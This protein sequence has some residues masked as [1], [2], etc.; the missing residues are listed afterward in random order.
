MS[1]KTAVRAAVIAMVAALAAFVVAALAGGAVS[2]KV[3]PG[4]GD[5][6]LLTRWG[7][8]IS[9]VALELTS[10]LTVGALMMAAFLLPAGKEGLGP[11][12]RRYVR[13][14]SW[15]AACWAVAAAATMVFTVS[16]ILAEP[17]GT[18]L[19]GNELSSYVGQLPEGTALM[20]VVLMSVVVALLARTTVS[21]GG[22]VGLLVLAF[23]ALLPEPVTTGHSAASPNHSVAI[24]SMALHI[25]G[26]V[27]WVGGLALLAWFAMTGGEAAL[28][29]PAERFS[30]AALVCYV[31]VGASGFANVV[32]R[33]ADPEQLFTSDYGRLVLVK[34]AAFAFLGWLGWTHRT[35]TLPAVAVRKPR[36][37]IRL[38]AVEVAIMAGTVGVAVALSRTPPPAESTTEDP[39]KSLL[40]YSM[41]PPLTTGR[42]F[43]LWRFDLYFAVLVAVLGGLYVAG[44]LRLRRRGDRWPVGRT[45]A[46]MIGL[47]TIVVVTMSG[48]ATY[49][50]ILF[51]VHMAQHMVLSML[52]PIF[53]VLGAPITLALRALKPA[54]VRG[55]RGPR[56]WLMI[57]LHSRVIKVLTHPAVATVIF[58]ASTYVLYFT[59]LFEA[60]MRAHLGHI[61]MLT[62]FLLAGGLFYWVLIGVDPAPHK[63]PYIARILVLFVTMP[64]HAFFGISLMNS[65]GLAESW[66]QSLGRSWGPSI[67]SDLHTGGSIAWAFGEIPTFI[68]LIAIVFQWF[69]EDQRLSQRLDRQAD[70][71]QSQGAGAGQETDELSDYNAY[72]ARLARRGEKS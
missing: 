2:E 14:A 1:T 66:Y 46:W 49:S 16:D 45:V 4:V 26:I 39:V 55:D 64:F 21:H 44:V 18:V 34:V 37:F 60:A 51:S 23:I 22:V 7:L 29:V 71:A 10:M 62:H 72:L 67:V 42:L 58:V 8:P 41:P 33:L 61:A 70:R 20:L 59:P 54:E 68:V 50:P 17:V 11:D 19:A 3:V 53:L 31:M 24:T 28:A 13:G 56:E 32:V 9:Q 36:A 48:V 40:G 15:L 57:I 63:L 25:A 43:T 6:G 27:P 30:R 69:A 5:S 38:A 12:A 52:T 47:L 35:R 65:S